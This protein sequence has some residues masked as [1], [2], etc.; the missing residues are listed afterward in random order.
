MTS[1]ADD[2]ARAGT[3]F[4]TV[5]ADLTEEDCRLVQQKT[6]SM[7]FLEGEVLLREGEP[8]ASMFIVRQGKVEIRKELGGGSYRRL[9]DLEAGDFFGEVSF[10]GLSHRTATVV[11]LNPGELLELTAKG[12]DALSDERPDIVVTLYR[13]MM[14]EL[15]LRLQHSTDD[16][17]QA[18]LWALEGFMV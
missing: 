2:A 13:N 11:A 10:L 14:R 5:F 9:K 6:R 4:M 18:A 3:T 17:K 15:A 8:G 1:A 7:A 16:M 12:M